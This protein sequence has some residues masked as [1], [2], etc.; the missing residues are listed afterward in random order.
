MDAAHTLWTCKWFTLQWAPENWHSWELVKAMGRALV[1]QTAREQIKHQDKG[2]TQKWY[3]I[4]MVCPRL[5]IMSHKCNGL[6]F[7]N[8]IL[9]RKLYETKLWKMFVDKWP[10]WFCITKKVGTLCDKWQNKR[11]KKINNSVWKTLGIG[12]QE[13]FV[14]G[15]KLTEQTQRNGEP[16]LLSWLSILSGLGDSAKIISERSSVFKVRLKAPMKESKEGNGLN[17]NRM[18]EAMACVF[19]AE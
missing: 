9:M 1:A 8:L 4:L 2:F 16:G 7:W 10:T 15:W 12:S 19:R 13:N 17:K 5:L 6:I 11:E 18:K 3:R 14:V